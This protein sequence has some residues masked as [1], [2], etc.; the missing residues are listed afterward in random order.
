MLEHTINDSPSRTHYV[1]RQGRNIKL[2]KD[3]YDN[4]NF[5]QRAE[6]DLKS[7]DKST[8]LSLK[9]GLKRFPEKTKKAT[10]QELTQLHE[11]NV[12]EPIRKSSMT[13]QEII[14][15]LNTLTFI[16]R[17]RFGRVKAR[18]CADGRPQRNLYQKWEASS[19]TLRTELVLITAMINAYEGRTI[20][21]YDIP[22][23]F[24]HAH[25]TDITYVKMTD[26]AATLLIEVSPT[27]Y[28]DYLILERYKNKIYLMLRKALY[29]CIKSALLFW[30]N[31]SGKLI[32]RGYEL[33]VYDR[34]VA[35]KI[36]NNTQITIIWHVDDLKISHVC[37]EVLEQE[38]K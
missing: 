8:Q 16:K 10:I 13:R 28:K 19:P 34:C 29:G 20:G 9:Q 21:V 27:T 6:N 4:Y 22:G 7:N 38:I 30:E 26:E 23:S 11:M 37:K 25:Q 24:L 32:M 17:K 33:N 5:L 12:F 2:R 15:T 14:G 18:T 1:T 35:N 31:F 3:L 36:I